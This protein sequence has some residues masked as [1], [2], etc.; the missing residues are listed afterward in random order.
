MY[1]V[2]VK[3]LAFFYDFMIH[4]MTGGIFNHMYVKCIYDALL[5]RYESSL[6]KFF[7]LSGQGN[8]VS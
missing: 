1:I 4:I 6:K 3:K 5:W 2:Q 8:L 7:S